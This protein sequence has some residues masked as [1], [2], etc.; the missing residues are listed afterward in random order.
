MQRLSDAGLL[1]RAAAEN[2]AHEATVALAHRE[3]W[4]SPSHRANLLGDYDSVGVAAVRDGQ[5][6]VWA[7]EMLTHR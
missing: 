1:V 7:V 4:E 6:S 3:L 2:V 5:G